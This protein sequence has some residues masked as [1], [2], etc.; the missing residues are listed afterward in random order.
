M[1]RLP[2][3]NTNSSPTIYKYKRKKRGIRLFIAYTVQAITISVFILL[4]ILIVCGCLYI[5]EHLVPASPSGGNQ[6][7]MLSG[8]YGLG[9]NG[10]WDNQAVDPTIPS[11]HT[12][13]VVLDP[14]HGGVQ[15]GCEFDGVLEKDISLN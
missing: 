11:A 9:E 3:C 1:D 10:A 15:A 8:L 13:I 14:G 7:D 5:R 4:F 2:K 6:G 12:A